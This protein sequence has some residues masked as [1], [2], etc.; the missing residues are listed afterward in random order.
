[1]IHGSG[2]DSGFWSKLSV[3][4]QDR[5]L[6]IPDMI[7]HGRTPAWST[8]G[9]QHEYRIEDDSDL[10]GEVVKLSGSPIDLIA[11]SVGATFSI[12]Y[13]SKCPQNIRKLVVIEPILP[14]LLISAAPE[15]WKE[16]HHTY[17]EVDRL[18]SQGD[19]SKASQM[20]FDFNLGSDAWTA[21]PD[22]AKAKIG[23]MIKDSISPQSRAALRFTLASKQ[24]RSLTMPILVIKG[25]AT[26]AGIQKMSELFA[27][28]VPSAAL[29]QVDG[30]T[31]LLPI[32]HAQT[33]NRLICSYLKSDTA[34]Y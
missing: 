32:T 24:L 4:L 19:Y 21:L 34:H 9:A 11:H 17:N 33:V 20:V 2:V 6:Y 3:G 30:A 22:S 28:A 27:Q 31:H 16:I 18:V 26:R 10:I 14:T 23:A 5:K 8:L 25:T 1:M 15:E 12:D 29:E 13:A 7:G